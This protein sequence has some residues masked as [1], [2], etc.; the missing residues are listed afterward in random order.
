MQKLTHTPGPWTFD[1]RLM[2][3]YKSDKSESITFPNRMGNVA[4][5]RLMGKAGQYEQD[6]VNGPLLAAS[7]EL[8]SALKAIQQW[9]GHDQSKTGDEMP[10]AI[11]NAM[12]A[13]IAK[14]KGQQP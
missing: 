14:A 3:V 5:C 4:I 11:F 8:L 13:A 1:N 6:D 2:M 9:W 10:S 7:P 12:N